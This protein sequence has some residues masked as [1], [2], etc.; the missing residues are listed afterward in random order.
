MC[1][2]QHVSSL[3]EKISFRWFNCSMSFVLPMVSQYLFEYLYWRDGRTSMRRWSLISLFSLSIRWKKFSIDSKIFVRSTNF[4]DEIVEIRRR[5]L[6]NWLWFCP[7][8][9]VATEIF[10]E[11]QSKKQNET[12]ARWRTIRRR[13]TFR[14]NDEENVDE[15]IHRWE[16][17]NTACHRLFSFRDRRFHREDS[18]KS[19]S[20]RFNSSGHGDFSNKK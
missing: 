5:S 19:T 3:F 4:H 10:F 8:K 11:F 17:R 18:R 16:E 12:I 9:I 2:V 7:F 15:E 1:F 20:T 6:F 13:K 14:T